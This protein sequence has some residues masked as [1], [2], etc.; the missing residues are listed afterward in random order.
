MAEEIY[1]QWRNIVE[2]T[3][4]VFLVWMLN[5]NPLMPGVDKMIIHT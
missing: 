2:I 5:L 3:L 4:N 1:G